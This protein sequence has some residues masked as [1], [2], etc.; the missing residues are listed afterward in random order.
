M[1]SEF[2]PRKGTAHNVELFKKGKHT[3]FAHYHGVDIELTVD[4]LVG[5]DK[6]VEMSKEL[7]CEF[8]LHDNPDSYKVYR[9]GKEI[10]E[11]QTPSRLSTD[12]L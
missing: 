8:Y 2:F 4:A 10:E 7:D 11:I 6:V 9:N 5:P 1:N 12:L 3:I